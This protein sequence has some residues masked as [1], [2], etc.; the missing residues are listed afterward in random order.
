ML[1]LARRTPVSRFG[2]PVPPAAKAPGFR[3]L[4]PISAAPR[5]GPGEGPR[6]RTLLVFGKKL[7]ALRAESAL[8]VP[9]KH[10][11]FV[12]VPWLRARMLPHSQAAGGVFSAPF[13]RV[14]AQAL[15]PR[16]PPRSPAAGVSKAGWQV[17]QA[18]P[19]TRSR[20]HLA[21]QHPKCPCLLSAGPSSH[22]QAH[23]RKVGGGAFIQVRPAL[24][25][26]PL[27]RLSRACRGHRSAESF[28]SDAVFATM[29]MLMVS[30]FAFAA[31]KA[32]P[33]TFP[34]LRS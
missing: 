24:A 14:A 6:P 2:R 11:A 17:L 33:S 5:Q 23:S 30:A 4:W 19:V 32:L 16:S 22:R 21:T 13:R 27:H 34:N 15:P 20:V 28:E 12:V 31:S 10:S 3:F 7:P 25:P 26:V 8:A 1:L 29:S 9:S 18:R